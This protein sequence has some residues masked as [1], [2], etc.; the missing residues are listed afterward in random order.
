M[1]KNLEITALF[2]KEQM[3]PVIRSGLILNYKAALKDLVQA[4]GYYY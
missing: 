4:V 1:Q 2:F 3:E